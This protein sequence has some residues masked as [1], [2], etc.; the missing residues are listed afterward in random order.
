VLTDGKGSFELGVHTSSFHHC[1]WKQTESFQLDVSL[2][3][4]V[5]SDRRLVPIFNW[6]KIHLDYVFLEFMSKEKRIH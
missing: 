2:A 5:L 6:K 4:T 3:G 1:W